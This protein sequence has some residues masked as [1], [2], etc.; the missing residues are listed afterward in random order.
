M[1]RYSSGMTRALLFVHRYLGIAIGLVMAMWCA[2]GIVMMYV[3]FPSL[4]DAAR[5]RALE[6]IAWEG[7]CAFDK[8]R[9]ALGVDV[10][11]D[12]NIEMV[13]G[14]PVLRVALAMGEQRAFDLIT[15]A[16]IES[17]DDQQAVAVAS[18]YAHSRGMEQPPDHMALALRDQWTVQDQFNRDRPLHRVAL[19]DPGGLELYVSSATGAIVQNTTRSERFWNWLGSIPHWLYPT[20]L[21][22]HAQLWSQTVIWL[23]LL[24]VF[25]TVIGLYIGVA[26]WRAMKGKGLSPYRGAHLWHHVSGLFFGVLALTWVGSGLVSMSPFGLFESTGFSGDRDRVRDVWIDGGQ[27]AAAIR[28][29]AGETTTRALSRIESAPLNGKLY[30]LAYRGDVARRIDALTL[31]D[32]PLQQLD[33]ERAARQL[34]SNADASKIDLL[35][36]GDNYYYSGHETRRLPVY[37]FIADDAERSHYYFDARSGDLAI[38][39]DANLRSYRWL[40]EGLH[41]FDFTGWL[42]KRPWWDLI[43]LPLML[44]VTVVCFTGAYIGLRRV[45]RK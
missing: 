20:A 37:R 4:D 35:A 15:G 17:F 32:A 34:A 44:G 27:I 6:P 11:D 36:E 21:R 33:I 26:H 16:R 3:R 2:S 41:R 14:R 31:A 5:L 12:F 1:F 13:A 10:A 43:V 42:R 7:C 45:V 25:L 19:N 38:K 18:R 40:F 30:L 8:I 24:G 23:S 39:F 22:Q 29:V 9:S 28:L